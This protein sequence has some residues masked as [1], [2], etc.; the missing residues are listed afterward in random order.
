M[1]LKIVF[2]QETLSKSSACEVFPEGMHF[3]S[4]NIIPNH[5]L[6]FFC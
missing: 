4:Y 6:K 3:L 1:K 2:E 5:N